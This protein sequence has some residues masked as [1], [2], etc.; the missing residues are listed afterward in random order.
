MFS[1]LFL[2]PAALFVLVAVPAV[3]T[4]KNFTEVKLRVK[5]AGII[6]AF[7]ICWFLLLSFS[8]WMSGTPNQEVNAQEL[9]SEIYTKLTDDC[10][11]VTQRFQSCSLDKTKKS[12][13]QYHES[14]A[15]FFTEWKDQWFYM[16][17]PSQNDPNFTGGL[18]P[19]K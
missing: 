1:F 13:N 12:C 8:A 11:R 14:K 7:A 19:P 5:A 6:S 16:C 17:D 18:L 15:W 10:S 9:Q 4:G 2:F 3:M